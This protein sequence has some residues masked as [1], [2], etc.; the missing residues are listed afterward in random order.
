MITGPSCAAA[1]SA[2]G[3]KFRDPA[4]CNIA[5][6]MAGLAPLNVDE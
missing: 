2:E 4:P 3:Q 1:T 5:Q 6:L